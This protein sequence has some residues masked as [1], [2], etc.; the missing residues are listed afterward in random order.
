[1]NTHLPYWL[2]ILFMPNVGMHTFLQWLPHFSNI[3]NFF[4]ASTN[5][6]L[7]AGVSPRHIDGIKNIN[8]RVIE[9]EMEWI[10]S[11]QA[12]SIISFEDAT[13]P[14]LLK[15]IS[16]PP[17]VLYVKG[18]VENLSRQQI[19]MVGSRQ[20]SPVGLKNA[21]YFA[22]SLAQAGLTI[23]SGLALGI[24]GASHRGALKVQGKTIGVAGTGLRHVYPRSHRQLVE[25]IIQK[26]GSIISEFPLML[27]PQASHF[28]RRNRIIS[29]LSIGVLVVEAVIKSGSLITARQALDQGREVF[30]IPGSI[31]QPQARGCHYLIQQ[32]AK[33]VGCVQD[34]LEELPLSQAFSSIKSVPASPQ[35]EKLSPEMMQILEKIEYAMTSTDAIIIESGLTA[36]E[37]SSI[38]LTL[39]LHGYIQAVRG[40][41]MRVV[42]MVGHQ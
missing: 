2:A 3:E 13:Y 29:G 27:S 34:I 21:E 5:E 18:Q 35:L 32:G 12:Q 33:L 16:S 20:A 6:L 10:D 4:H 17:P 11:H 19:A 41:Y 28:P 39:E 15:T 31:H 8:W 23:T 24:D 37:V 22:A 9:K 14:P 42:N 26:D 25:E 36:G 38:L 7:A 40:G 1:M 30:A